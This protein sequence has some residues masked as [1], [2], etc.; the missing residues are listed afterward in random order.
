MKSA[1][2]RMLA[3][4]A[5]LKVTVAGLLLLMI[6]TIWGTLYQ[7]EH[8]LYQAQ[9]R[10]YQS[11]FLWIWNLIPF[12]GAQTV[13]TVLFVNLGA[14]VA[15]MALRRKLSV[16]FVT[17][18]LGLALLLGLHVLGNAAHKILYFVKAHNGI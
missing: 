9:E 17:T 1:A 5:S 2:Q 8:G 12:P 3:V 7:A 13:M 10:F 6:L 11:W 18:H 4:L 14:S 15:Y 16:G